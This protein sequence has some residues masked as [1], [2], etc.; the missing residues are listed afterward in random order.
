M[1]VFGFVFFSSP[2]NF[3]SGQSGSVGDYK[4]SDLFFSPSTGAFL[5][6]STFDVSIAINTN[7]E[8]VNAFELYIKFPP[9]KLSVVNSFGNKSI[10]SVWTEAPTYSNTAG[11]IH[12]QGGVMGGVKTNA[13]VILSLT[14]KAMMPGPADIQILPTSKILANDGLATSIPYNVIRGNYTISAKPPEG[15]VVSSDTHPFEDQWYN[16]NNIA[17]SWESQDGAA[18]FSYVFDDKPNTIPDDSPVT[19][20]TTATFEHVKDG[21]SYFHIKALKDGVWGPVTQRAF[22]IDTGPPADFKP[23]MQ[24]LS[25]TISNRAMLSFFTTDSLSGVDYYEVGVVDRSKSATESPIFI[26]AESPYQIPVDINGNYRAIVR[27]VD[28]AGNIKEESLDIYQP[29]FTNFIVD[30][31]WYILSVLFAALGYLLFDLVWRHRKR[32]S[33]VSQSPLANPAMFRQRDI[34]FHQPQDDKEA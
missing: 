24:M 22:Y 16:N 25:A 5:V 10:I 26:Q 28:K 14:F 23:T 12:L 9:D 20:D 7:G 17:I 19:A 27:A 1:A 34:N 11:T 8:S 21:I 2:V 29:S 13:G 31:S 6:D 33:L 32:K 30:Y 3:A 4:K 15:V 18:N